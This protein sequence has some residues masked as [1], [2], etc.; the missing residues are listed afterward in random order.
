MQLQILPMQL[1]LR[2]LSL[3][4]LKICIPE[5]PI[6]LQISQLRKYFKLGIF[7]VSVRDLAA[8]FKRD[9]LKC[10]HVYYDSIDSC[11]FHLIIIGK[12]V[13]IHSWVHNNFNVTQGYIS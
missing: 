11:S 6:S 4:E 5:L 10:P 2:Q 12:K 9:L 1:L 3:E 7:L 13:I 8:S